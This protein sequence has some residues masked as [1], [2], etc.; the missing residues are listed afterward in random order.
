[1]EVITRRETY[2]EQAAAYILHL[3]S[4]HAW[5]FEQN[6]SWNARNLHAGQLQESCKSRLNSC[7]PNS[8]VMGIGQLP[9]RYYSAASPAVVA[10]GTGDIDRPV[11]PG[12]DVEDMMGG[13]E[14]AQKN[15]AL[16][17]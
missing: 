2:L 11:E 9:S 16:G 10:V 13:L 12:R 17:I 6:G 4:C 3:E 1:M 7:S 5:V 8:G 15:A 14:G